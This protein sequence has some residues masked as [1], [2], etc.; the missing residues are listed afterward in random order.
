M[1]GKKHE[2]GDN[3]ETNARLL[4]IA[5]DITTLSS[6]VS[7]PKHLSLAVYLHHNFGSRKLIEA[8]SALGHCISYTE[9]RTFITS[10][11]MHVDAQQK[12]SKV[13]A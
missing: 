9:L 7:S 11:V 10:A 1:D 13:N 6:A 3:I 8:I 2:T 5:C 4:S 12:P